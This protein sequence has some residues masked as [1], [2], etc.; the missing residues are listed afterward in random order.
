[1]V[2]YSNIGRESGQ[3]TKHFREFLQYLQEN[4]GMVSHSIPWAKYLYITLSFNLLIMAS[5]F[6]GSPGLVG[7][8]HLIAEVSRLRSGTPQSVRLL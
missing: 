4:A 8:D 5:F 7:L 6:H 3:F 2:P 1:M